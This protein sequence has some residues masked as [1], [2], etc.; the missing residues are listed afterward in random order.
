GA[1][2]IIVERAAEDAELVGGLRERFWQT[3]SVRARPA[4]DAAAAAE[5]S[6]KFRDYFD[7]TEPLATMPSHRVLAVL[8]GEKEQVLAL[9]LDG[10]DDAM[11]QAMIATA[12]AVDLTAGSAAT[13]WLA[14]TVGFAWRTRLSVSASVDARV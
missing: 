3:G 1:R 4:S 5:K 9:S 6:Q 12:L 8:R 7:H 11:Y 13:P 10:G 2:H 14:A